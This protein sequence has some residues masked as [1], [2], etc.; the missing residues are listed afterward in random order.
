MDHA[1]TATQKTIL[2]AFRMDAGTVKKRA[3]EL[4]ELLA[5]NEKNNGGQPHGGNEENHHA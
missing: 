4:S 2:G 5:G 1:V 3:N